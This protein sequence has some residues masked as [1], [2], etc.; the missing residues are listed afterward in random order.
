MNYFSQTMIDFIEQ[1]GA[2][3][4]RQTGSSFEILL[5]RSKKNPEKWIFP[6]GHIEKGETPINAA[7]R[8]LHEEAG[9]CGTSIQKI[10][11]LQ[12]S[13][14]SRTYNVT[15]YISRF[16]YSDSDGEVGREPTWFS[17]DEALSVISIQD[18]REMLTLAVPVIKHY[19]N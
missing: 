1:A 3:T 12:Y 17:I 9:V 6:K 18:M 19:L 4:F 10:G 7:E 5:V 8:E 13:I 14:N 16:L 15:Y 2:I 11:I